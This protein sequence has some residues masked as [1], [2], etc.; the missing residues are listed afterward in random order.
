MA[1]RIDNSHSQVQ[2]VVRHMMISNV[3]GRFETFGGTV[4]FNEAEPEKS[5]VDVQIEAASLNTRDANRDN[6]LRSPDFFDV[7]KYPYITFRSTRI[8][9][10]D[11][12]TGRI[13]GDLT[14]RGVTHP[15]TLD[16]EYAGQSKMWGNTSAGFSATT[17]ISRKEWGLTWNQ[18]L[19]S[20]G[21]LVGD[22]VKIE[23]EL[24]IVKVPETESA[25]E[26]VAA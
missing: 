23:V 17:R 21:M 5:S 7:E 9:K 19:E 2:F 26:T 20:G 11:D 15:V 25:K 22:Q 24:E 1:W 10:L 14:I 18:T 3:R 8:E 12:N 13:A 6:H 4:D 16:V